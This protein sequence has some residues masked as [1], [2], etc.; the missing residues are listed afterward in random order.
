MHCKIV[1]LGNGCWTYKHFSSIIQTREYRSPEVLFG[2]FY[3][4]SAD[5]WSCAC[6][7]IGE[8]IRYNL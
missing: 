7:L 6:K 3:D 4:T 8:T 2:Q 5:I 1:D